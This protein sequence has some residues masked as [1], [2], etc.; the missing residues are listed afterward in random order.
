[1]CVARC[2]DSGIAAEESV[3]ILDGVDEAERSLLGTFVEIGRNG[4]IDIAVGPITRDYRLAAHPSVG[5]RIRP[6]RASKI[7]G[8]RGPGRGGLRTLQQDVP[9][10][11]PVLGVLV[12]RVAARTAPAVRQ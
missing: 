10:V 3:R 11:L 6:R 12:G 2:A 7:R 4:V 8:I 5:L 9:E 1:V